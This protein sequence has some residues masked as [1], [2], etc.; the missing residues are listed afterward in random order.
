RGFSKITRDVTER[1]RAEEE[2]KRLNEDLK[3][4]AAKLEMANQELE[5]FSYSVS[6]DLRAPLRTIDGFSLALLEDY[7]DRVDAT[8]QDYLQRVRAAAQRMAQLIDD[9]LDLSRVTRAEMRRE[10]VD[11]S[12][13]AR[14][15]ADELRKTQ[16]ERQ[17]AFVIADGL[18]AEGD[19][20][21]LQVAL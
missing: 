8:G 18:T 11:L 9:L 13:L 21:L 17:V 14:E 5:A 12:A 7:K 3:A 16:P 10:A 19:T 6:H 1:K 2:I 15:I 4:H 20:R